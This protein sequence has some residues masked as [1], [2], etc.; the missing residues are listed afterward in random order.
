[1][2]AACCWPNT[3]NIFPFFMRHRIL[4]L[5]FITSLA[6]YVAPQNF[7]L[8]LAF[9]FLFFTLFALTTKSVF[10]SLSALLFITQHFLSPGKYYSFTLIEAGQLLTEPYR[11]FGIIDGYG[12]TASDIFAGLLIVYYFRSWL[13]SFFTKKKYYLFLYMNNSVNK[14]ILLCWA[15]YVIISIYSSF[16]FSFYPVFSLVNLL[17]YGKIFVFFI[18]F[19]YIFTQ[20]KKTLLRNSGLLISGF[21]L[22]NFFIAAIQFVRDVSKTF[23]AERNISYYTSTEQEL[24]ISAPTGF[25]LHS[26]QF[27]LFSLLWV[28]I[29]AYIYQRTKQKFLLYIIALNVLGVLISQSRTVWFICIVITSVIVWRQKHQIIKFAKTHQRKMLYSALCAL[30]FISGMLPRISAL[31]YTFEGGS[32]SI[33]LNMLSEGLEALQLNP[34]MGYGVHTGVRILHELF[35]WGYIQNFPFEIH[36]AYLQMSLESGIIGAFFFF[37]PFFVLFRKNISKNRRFYPPTK[38]VMM[39]HVFLIGAIIVYYI[40]QPHGGRLEIPL[41]GVIVAF[42]SSKFYHA[43]NT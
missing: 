11:T 5:T 17:Q 35:P 26:N 2:R 37:I 20:R 16:Y 29:L 30:I 41:L 18:T 31:Q 38:F 33:R 8:F 27:A 24:R 14:F 25:Y 6:L 3:M 42:S 40:F 9:T 39:L 12:L 36:N 43:N 10:F 21:S 13:S 23:S 22:A 28:L 19:F 32:G 1:M 4:I 7:K 34:W 15:V